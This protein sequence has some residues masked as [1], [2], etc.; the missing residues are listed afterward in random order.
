MRQEI[1]A[2]FE[3]AAIQIESAVESATAGGGG[4]DAPAAAPAAEKQAKPAKKMASPKKEASP[5]MAADGA[6]PKRSSKARL[7]AYFKKVNP[8][9]LNSV[10]KL[11]GSYK[12]K[13]EELFRKLSEKYGQPVA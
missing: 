11:L 2:M 8:D 10:D 9:K 1:S 3:D 13:E 6:K 7:T 4:G 12:G 5:D